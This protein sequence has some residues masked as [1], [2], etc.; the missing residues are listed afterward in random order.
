MDKIKTLQAIIGSCPCGVVCMIDVEGD[1]VLH[2][3]EFITIPNLSWQCMCGRIHVVD[4]QGRFIGG[5]IN[6]EFSMAPG[7]KSPFKVDRG[8]RRIPENL[9]DA[10]APMET[11]I[12]EK[13]AETDTNLE[14]GTASPYFMTEKEC[15]HDFIYSHS[16]AK[17]EFC[18]K[19]GLAR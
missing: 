18:R 19:C 13:Q 10:P 2:N 12:K 11:L 5:K 9:R 16:G 6:L 14:N 8:E 17:R 15:E 1:N 7:F 3:A 4:T